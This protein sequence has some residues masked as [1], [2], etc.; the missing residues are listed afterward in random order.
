[1]VPGDDHL[2]DK[3]VLLVHDVLHVDRVFLSRDREHLAQRHLGLQSVVELDHDVVVLVVKVLSRAGAVAE[4]VLRVKGDDVA[5]A[6]LVCIRDDVLSP[7]ALRVPGHVL[8][9]V[10]GVAA[11]QPHQT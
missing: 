4:I 5:L 10:A 6:E 9:D 3:F 1:M 2:S 8:D 11:V 7:D